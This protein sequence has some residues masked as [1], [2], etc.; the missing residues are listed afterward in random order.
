MSTDVCI[1]FDSENRSAYIYL[2]VYEVDRQIEGK[3]PVVFDVDAD[4]DVV[5][6]EILS[7]PSTATECEASQ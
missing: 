6:I 3:L 2:R 1:T 7:V 4:G 5:G